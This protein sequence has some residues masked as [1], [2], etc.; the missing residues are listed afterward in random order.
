[1]I[2]KTK[3]MLTHMVLTLMLISPLT[4][5]SQSFPNKPIK[6]IVTYPPGGSSD[7]IARTIG[8]KLNVLWGQPVIL[9]YKAG[10]A[11][12]IGMDFVAHQPAD[13]YTLVLGN[14]GPAMVGPMLTKTSYSM[15]K[16]FIPVTLTTVA[17]NVLV[18][19][20]NSPYKT[21]A[22]L[23]AA[24]KAKPMTLNFATSGPG[25]MSDISTELFMR[26]AKIR[27]VKVPYKGGVPAVNDLIGGQ[28]DLMISDAYPVAQF[29]KTGKL[30]A[31]AITSPTRSALVPGVPTFAELGQPGVVAMTWW[32][33]FLPAGVPTAIQDQ[34]SKALIKIMNDADIKENF[35]N[36]SVEAVSDTQEEFKAFLAAETA[37]YGKLI[38]DNNIKGE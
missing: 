30:R 16:D 28:V 17:P 24:A 15:D 6:F 18:V 37:R 10:A 25:S 2:F 20:E 23:I 36:L 12:A 9:D 27:M 8:R 14:F 33:V 11:G 1:M 34:Y 35:A 21:L 29:I 3:N 22:D 38:A 7:L 19:P 32:G 26:E 13:G 31:L 5:F 4:V